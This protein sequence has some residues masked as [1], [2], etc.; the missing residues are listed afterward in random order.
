MRSGYLCTS[1]VFAICAASAAGCLDEAS[2]VAEDVSSTAAPI[3]STTAP[4]FTE[5]ELL[6]GWKNVPGASGRNAG[7]ALVSNIVRFKGW[8][9]GGGR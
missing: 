2:P 8:I 4:T 1:L 3:L 7:V 5:L 6:N 9:D